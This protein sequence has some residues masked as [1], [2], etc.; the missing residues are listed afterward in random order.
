[1]TNNKITIDLAGP[2]GN[3]FVLISIAQNLAEKHGKDAGSIEKDMVADDYEHLLQVFE[4]NFGNFVV[5]LN[6]R[7]TYR[8]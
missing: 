1:M 4:K 8:F 2:D 6:R 7:E 5:L 3:A